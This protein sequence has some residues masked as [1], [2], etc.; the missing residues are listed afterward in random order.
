MYHIL[1]DVE[2]NNKNIE[3]DMR[4]L[5]SGVQVNTIITYSETKIARFNL[6]GLK[7]LCQ[8]FEIQLHDGGTSLDIIVTT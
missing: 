8:T 5:H 6:I 2:V 3:T 7:E 4:Q 1:N